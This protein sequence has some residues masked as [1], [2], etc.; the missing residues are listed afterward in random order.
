MGRKKTKEEAHVIKEVRQ[1]MKKKIKSVSADGRKSC[2]ARGLQQSL[3]TV[4]ISPDVLKLRETIAR[5]AQQLLEDR[6][7]PPEDFN[8]EPLPQRPSE[9]GDPGEM[10]SV[11]ITAER[12]NGPDHRENVAEAERSQ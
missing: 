7:R 10:L 6:A 9:A 11:Q 3:P 1:T 8:G 2:G 4:P 5:L 12:Q